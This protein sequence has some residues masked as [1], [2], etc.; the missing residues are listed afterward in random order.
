V[1]W[2]IAALLVAAIA[3]AQGGRQLDVPLGKTVEVKVDYA[4]G[5]MCDDPSL[6]DA[7]M[8]TRDDSNYWRVTGKKLGSTQCR[9]GTDPA[10]VPSIVFDLHV[11]PPKK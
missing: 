7:E 2:T 8:I 9:V 4:R 3:Q 1:K 6:V 5:W 11:V 10:Q